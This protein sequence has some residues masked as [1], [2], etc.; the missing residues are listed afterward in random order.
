M[1]NTETGAE[2]L[3]EER[4]VSREIGRE[5]I[6]MVRQME[7]GVHMNQLWRRKR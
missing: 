3:K 4:L 7:W 2:L 6:Q 1:C 5:R